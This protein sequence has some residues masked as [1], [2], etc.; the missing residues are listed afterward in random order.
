M[1]EATTKPSIVT[2]ML[3]EH[4]HAIQTLRRAMLLAATGLTQIQNEATQYDAGMAI[5]AFLDA[6]GEPAGDLPVAFDPAERPASDDTRP[7]YVR[8]DDE[9]RDVSA[10]W[11]G[12]LKVFNLIELDLSERTLADYH[13]AL[14][15]L[16]KAFGLPLSRA[17][18]E[19]NRD[20]YPGVS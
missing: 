12:V 17:D 13:A 10:F 9:R 15:E 2:R 18:F 16:F 7:L 14:G 11:K 6:V 19:A 20:A 8:I 4:P 5:E 1:T 3:D